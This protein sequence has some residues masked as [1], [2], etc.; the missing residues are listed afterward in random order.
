VGTCHRRDAGFTTL[1]VCQRSPNKSGGRAERLGH[2]GCIVARVVEPDH[3]LIGGGADPT[4]CASWWRRGSPRRSA[5]S[6]TGTDRAGGCRSPMPA[7][8]RREKSRRWIR[9]CDL[10][11]PIAPE[12]VHLRCPRESRGRRE[13]RVPSAPAVMRKNAHDRPQVR[14]NTRPSLRSG[15][16]GLW[17]APRR[18]IR[19]AS[20][21]DGLAIDRSPVGPDN[22]HQLD[23]SNG[24]Q[25]HT[26]LP[27]AASLARRPDRAHVLP[28]EVSREGV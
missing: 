26:V 27:S 7:V 2:Q 23:T 1:D 18:R 10:A 11:T 6:Q 22:L 20:V 28:A 4:R 24:C 15:F 3:V 13:S 21:A 19:L 8:S 17:R 9:H 12:V 25:D 16:N 5:A 14:R